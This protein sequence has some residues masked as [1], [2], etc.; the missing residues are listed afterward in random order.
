M[1][2]RRPG[3]QPRRVPC[4]SSPRAAH[5]WCMPGLGPAERSDDRSMV[6]RTAARGHCERHAGRVV[7]LAADLLPYQTH[8]T[9]APHLVMHTQ[10]DMPHLVHDQ[11]LVC[12]AAACSGRTGPHLHLVILDGRAAVVLGRLQA[13]ALVGCRAWR[14]GAVALR[15]PTQGRRSFQPAGESVAA[16]GWGA[17]AA[18]LPAQRQRGLAGAQHAGRATGA[19]RHS[20]RPALPQRAPQAAPRLILSPHTEPARG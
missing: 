17:Q 13:L 20:R 12:R 1:R 14:V 19:G 16:C 7:T 2:Q 11:P 3:S 15:K 5:R 6:R 9:W 4:K 10:G 18:H 8:H